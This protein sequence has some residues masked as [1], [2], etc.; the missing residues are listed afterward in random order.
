MSMVYAGSSVL[1]DYVYCPGHQ[2]YEYHD[3]GY[4]HQHWYAYPPGAQYRL[5]TKTLPKIENGSCMYCF[6]AMQ[7]TTDPQVK[8]CR[9]CHTFQWN[10]V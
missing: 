2:M 3:Y 8:Y 4:P 5:I 6:M 10:R 7:T 9:N 1:P